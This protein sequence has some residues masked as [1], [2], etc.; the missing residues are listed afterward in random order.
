MC[1]MFWIETEDW[2]LNAFEVVFFLKY[3]LHKFSSICLEK[4]MFQ[5]ISEYFSNIHL[6]VNE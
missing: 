3:T 4:T 5:V 1:A 2:I 6:P